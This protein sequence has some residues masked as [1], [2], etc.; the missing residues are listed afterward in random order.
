[1]LLMGLRHC[2]FHSCSMNGY[3]N[4]AEATTIPLPLCPVCLRKLFQAVGIQTTNR[5]VQRYQSLRVFCH[6]NEF[7]NEARWYGARSNLLE[8]QRMEG[9]V[10][11]LQEPRK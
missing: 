4:L 8:R 1:M 9:F 11:A 5:C 2:A 3:A 10:K 7:K 6:V